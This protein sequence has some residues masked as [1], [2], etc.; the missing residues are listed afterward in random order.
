MTPHRVHYR[1]RLGESLY[2]SGDEG[3]SDTLLGLLYFSIH[4]KSLVDH[5][6]KRGVWGGTFGIGVDCAALRVLLLA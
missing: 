5:G 6:L 1:E 3:G 4:D 2:P